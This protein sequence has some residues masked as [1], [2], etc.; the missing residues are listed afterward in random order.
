MKKYRVWYNRYEGKHIVSEFGSYIPKSEHAS[1]LGENGADAAC[2]KLN[3]KQRELCP[4]ESIDIDKREFKT[5]FTGLIN[6]S[7]VAD[8]TK[9][10]AELEYGQKGEFFEKHANELGCSAGYLSQFINK[11]LG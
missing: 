4:S 1:L 9:K 3:I 2:K 6:P 8:I 10:Y 5:K 7:I 11:R